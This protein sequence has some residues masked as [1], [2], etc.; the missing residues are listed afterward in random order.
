MFETIESYQLNMAKYVHPYLDTPPDSN[1]KYASMVDRPVNALSS[2]A[3]SELV[4]AA[5]ESGKAEI[6]TLKTPSGPLQAILSKWAMPTGSSSQMHIPTNSKAALELQLKYREHR[7]LK[8]HKP[9]LKLN[10][11]HL[12][13]R[14]ALS[15]RVDA[16][17]FR[18][19]TS[20][21][22]LP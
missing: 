15:S 3:I 21:L 19:S 14:W 13:Y 2:E 10:V 12:F 1:F 17:V 6:M 8:D 7:L 18:R 9:P 22:T 5:F 11:A 20:N 16:I 4:E